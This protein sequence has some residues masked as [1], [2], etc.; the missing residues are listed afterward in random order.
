MRIIKLGAVLVA[1]A[2]PTGCGGGGGDVVGTIT[3]PIPTSSQ[4]QIALLGQGG[5]DQTNKQEQ[6][7]GNQNTNNQPQGCPGGQ[8]GTPPNCRPRGPGYTD[9][10]GGARAALN[11]LYGLRAARPTPLYAE[12]N[13]HASRIHG[14]FC[15]SDNPTMS[16]IKVYFEGSEVESLRHP[17]NL[18]WA[19]PTDV[20][21]SR[22]FVAEFARRGFDGSNRHGHTYGTWGDWSYAY[23]L[24][25]R[26]NKD[27]N[28]DTHIERH[29]RAT[30][31]SGGC[32][33]DRRNDNG[34]NGCVKYYALA[35][36]GGFHYRPGV[37]AAFRDVTATYE[38]KTWAT[39]LTSSEV[40]PAA[41]KW[42]EPGHLDEPAIVLPQGGHFLG[43]ATI[44]MNI[45]PI[46]HE[47]NARF[48]NFKSSVTGG[49]PVNLVDPRLQDGLNLDDPGF[50]YGINFF[51]VPIS[52]SGR[53][54][55]DTAGKYINGAF[56][57]PNGQEVAGTWYV[58]NTNAI[59][60]GSRSTENIIL[61]SF[62]AAEQ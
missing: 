42:K 17:D 10:L 5:T 62:V 16:N 29:G 12:A 34:W 24:Q 52:S 13:C 55:Q 59:D 43:D 30:G 2:I 22:Q 8:T 36:F 45:A 6:G 33:R 28:N 39:I 27:N 14:S 44:T 53:F 56:L 58:D 41:T 37:E 19:V 11:S 18:N 40:A 54:T 48:H 23:T 35:N 46:G 20:G 3:D 60:G 61:G 1:A 26:V 49:Q 31:V 9:T 15:D 32:H 57:G 7:D 25:G 38:G 47:F 51:R 4:D 50:Q 21:S